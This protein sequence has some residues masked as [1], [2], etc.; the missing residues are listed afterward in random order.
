MSSLAVSMLTLLFAPIS[1]T[2]LLV[3]SSAHCAP[4]QQ[5]VPIV[6]RMQRD[7]YPI[8]KIDAWQDQQTANR[9]GVTGVPC[10]ILVSDGQVVD[11]I[12][13]RTSIDSLVQMYRKAGYQLDASPSQLQYAQQGSPQQAYPPQ[14]NQAQSGDSGRPDQM[15]VSAQA[16]SNLESQYA[17]GS[18]RNSS[19]SSI[20]PRNDPTAAVTNL[21]PAME[22]A[23]RATVRLRVEDQS[24]VGVGSGTIIHQQGGEALVLTCGHLFRD[25]NGNC[26][27]NVEYGFPGRTE[28]VE[29]QLLDFEADIHDTALVVIRPAGRVDSVQVALPTYRPMRGDQIFSIGCDR[30]ADPTVRASKIKALTDYSRVQKYDIFGRP[31]DGRSGGG[32][33][34]AGGQLIGICNAAAVEVDEGIFA[35]MQSIHQQFAT[36]GLGQHFEDVQRLDDHVDPSQMI[37]NNQGATQGASAAVANPN[38]R[39]SEPSPNFAVP[40]TRSIDATP[41]GRTVSQPG[42]VEMIVILRDKADPSQTESI[43]VNNPSPEMIR[44]VQGH[45]NVQGQNVQGQNAQGQNAQVDRRMTP[46]NGGQAPRLPRNDRIASRPD[47][48]QRSNADWNAIQAP[49]DGPT[50]RAQSP[51]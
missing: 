21:T 50:Y 45:S 34:T 30:G 1:D 13:G 11:R 16:N 48:S 44:L 10:F 3:F 14:T 39:G 51:R 36:V 4:C 49:T 47:Q 31:I 9:F 8:T 6:E 28:T 20:A 19:E 37:A 46:V 2:Q 12:D 7:G 24:G 25:S 5:M 18:T 33:F 41:V 43:V 35:G 42:N 23:L 15:Y 29:G 22:R 17:P 40:D 26:R 27:I 38:Q 32:L